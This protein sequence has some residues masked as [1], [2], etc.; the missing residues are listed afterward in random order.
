MGRG[1]YP[2]NLTRPTSLPPMWEGRRQKKVEATYISHVQPTIVTLCVFFS[3]R[4]RLKPFSRCIS[5]RSFT[6]VS[7]STREAERLVGRRSFVFTPSAFTRSGESIMRRSQ[8]FMLFASTSISILSRIRAQQGTA[9]SLMERYALPTGALCFQQ[10]IVV[11]V[12]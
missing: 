10:P 12:G 1:A 7:R 8:S 4:A 5:P 9:V 2:G 6:F 3:I 11:N